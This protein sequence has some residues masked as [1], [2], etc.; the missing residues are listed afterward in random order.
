MH[1]LLRGTS[2]EALHFYLIYSY[3]LL[4]SSILPSLSNGRMRFFSLVGACLDFSTQK[5]S[6][7]LLRNSINISRKCTNYGDE[8]NNGEWMSLQEY[9][10]ASEIHLD[11]DRT[12]VK[13]G[14]YFAKTVTAKF[15]S[16]NLHGFA[17]NLC[18]S[19]PDLHRSACNLCGSAP[20]LHRSAYNLCGSAPDMRGSAPNLCGSALKLHGTAYNLHASCM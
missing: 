9:H 2:L 4:M 10:Q 13:C 1:G 16:L 18:G 3:L 5:V 11:V 7:T 19:A 8:G 20:D 15:L 17:C 14:S 6:T 12:A